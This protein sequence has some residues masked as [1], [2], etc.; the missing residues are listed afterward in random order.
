MSV[1]DDDVQ[2]YAL[3]AVF[4]IVALVVA[5]VVA[6]ACF[7]TLQS[8]P[9]SS[10]A[11]RIYFEADG[12][13]LSV[14][15]NEALAAVA[16]AARGNGQVLL[17][18]NGVHEPRGDTAAAQRRALRVRHALEANGVPATQLVLSK[19]LAVRAAGG[20]KESRRVD[21]RTE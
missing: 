17:L 1:Q 6:L 21:V 2:G 5:G 8:P 20:S 10:A 7:K 9:E 18:I 4:G 15:A 11:Q 12:D 13:T 19:P 14:A 16:E 3:G